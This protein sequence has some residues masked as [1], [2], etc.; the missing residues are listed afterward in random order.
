MALRILLVDDEPLGRAQLAALLEEH[1]GA[2]VAGS[3]SSGAEAA[4]FL[5]F[6]WISR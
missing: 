6:F 4:A 5:C 3:V 2:A 1:P